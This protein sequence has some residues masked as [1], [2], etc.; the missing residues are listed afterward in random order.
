LLQLLPKS[1][2][3]W[4]SIAMD[5]IINLPKAQGFYA[6]LIIVDHFNKLAHMV[7]TRRT[8]IAYETTCSFLM[9]GGSITCFQ[10]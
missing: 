10:E 9:H 2:G 3:P 1:P 7:P 8:V 4:H 6:L 5:L